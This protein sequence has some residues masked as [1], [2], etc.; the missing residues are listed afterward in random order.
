MN[1]TN[2]ML[3]GS[4]ALCSLFGSEARAQKGAEL[5]VRPNAIRI[6]ER[7]RLADRE[8]VRSAQYRQPFQERDGAS[9]QSCFVLPAGGEEGWR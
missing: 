2:L 8:P 5:L 9:F 3:A 7:S 4:L 1:S 6:I